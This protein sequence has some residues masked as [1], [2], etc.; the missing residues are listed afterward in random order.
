[1]D[2]KDYIALGAAF[3]SL[4]S[5]VISILSW[6]FAAR[7]KGSELRAVLLSSL[8]TTLVKAENLLSDYTACKNSALDAKQI[9]IFK[10]LASEDEL[11]G[12]TKEV[13][14]TLDEVER[15]SGHATIK[16]YDRVIA[17]S[18]LLSARIDDIGKSMSGLKTMILQEIRSASDAERSNQAMQPT[19]GGSDA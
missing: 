6:R 13:E 1:V 7:T 2:P 10:R 17:H 18:T 14:I 19:A 5:L 11:R 12:F 16:L 3:L 15:A 4:V 9:D 8:H